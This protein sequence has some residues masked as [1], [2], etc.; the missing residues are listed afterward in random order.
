MYAGIEHKN[1]QRKQKSKSAPR[2]K[3]GPRMKNRNGP[4]MFFTMKDKI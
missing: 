4:V 2:S 1:P 3:P